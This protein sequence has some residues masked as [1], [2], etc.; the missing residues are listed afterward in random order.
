MSSVPEYPWPESAPDA[1]PPVAAVP[2][3]VPAPDAAPPGIVRKNPKLAAFLALFPGVGHVYNGLYIRALTFFLIAFSLI[4]VTDRE[5][6]FGFATAFFWIFN[7]IDSYRQAT[8]INYGFAQDLGMLDLPQKP[9]AVQGGLLVGILLTLIGVYSFL[10]RFFRIDLRW[11][12][13]LWP[14]ALVGIGLWLIVGSIR[15]RRKARMAAGL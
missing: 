13:E 6:I 7:V 9:R 11:L 3:P 4:L 8:L 2:G 14:L 1:V 12:V 15:D 5:D 10:D